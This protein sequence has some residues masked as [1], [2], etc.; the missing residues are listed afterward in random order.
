MRRIGAFAFVRRQGDSLTLSASE[1]GSFVLPAI[2]NVR[3]VGV[4]AHINTKLVVKADAWANYEAVTLSAPHDAASH[5]TVRLDGVAHP[6]GLTVVQ[7][8][9]GDLYLV[10]PASAASL[11]LVG[12]AGSSGS[13]LTIESGSDASTMRWAVVDVLGAGRKLMQQYG[14]KVIPPIT[15]EQVNM[16]KNDA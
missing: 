5:A 10:D 1:P 9:S 3:Y 6:E 13:S 8:R 16:I 7:G 11:T 2:R 15:L 4:S 14:L 12:A